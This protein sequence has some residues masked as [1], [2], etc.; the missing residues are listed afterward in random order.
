MVIEKKFLQT[1]GEYKV[2][3]VDA[4]KVRQEPSMMDFTVASHHR[5]DA[6]I[7]P[8]EI[9]VDKNLKGRDLQ[10]IVRHEFWETEV[11]KEKHLGYAEAHEI[12]TAKEMK[13]R[14]IT[15][16]LEGLSI[17]QLK[18]MPKRELQEI[19]DNIGLEEHG[20]SENELITNLVAE[21]LETTKPKTIRKQ[22]R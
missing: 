18:K 4:A 9:W 19:C 17:D 1:I 15:K 13:F 7:P 10:A 3:A 22:K 2:Y 11:M 14:G 5:V 16:K 12:A 6:E 8:G 21:L 20:L